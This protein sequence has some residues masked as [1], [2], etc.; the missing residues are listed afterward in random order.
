MKNQGSCGSGW[1]FGA[2]AAM[3]SL[4]MFNATEQSLLSEQQL[5]DCSRRYSNRGCSEGALSHAYNYILENG[6]ADG[7]DY[8]YVGSEQPC[9][10]EGGPNQLPGYTQWK[11]K[12]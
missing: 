11:F 5:V 10:K 9:K 8:P 2:V 3:E 1:A 6:I 4:F 7:E 12:G